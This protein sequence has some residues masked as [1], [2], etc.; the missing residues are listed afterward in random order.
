MALVLLVTDFVARLHVHCS[1]M[2]HH[3][4]ASQLWKVVCG[5]RRGL[6]YHLFLWQGHGFLIRYYLCRL[7][8]AADISTSSKE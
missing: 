8:N 4:L 3:Y 5:D 6:G 1:R 2:C 7:H